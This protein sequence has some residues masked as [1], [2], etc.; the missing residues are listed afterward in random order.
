M[1]PQLSNLALDE[2]PAEVWRQAARLLE[3]AL[4]SAQKRIAD[5]ERELGP[6]RPRRPS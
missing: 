6:A 5:L 3:L 4:V 2:A 1:A